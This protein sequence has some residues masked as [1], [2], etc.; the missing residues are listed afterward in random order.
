MTVFRLAR[1]SGDLVMLPRRENHGRSR[2]AGVD[3]NRTF[4]N[5]TSMAPTDNTDDDRLALFSLALPVSATPSAMVWSLWQRAAPSKF[6]SVDL[7][8][9]ASGS[10]RPVDQSSCPQCQP[11]GHR[12][13]EYGNVLLSFRFVSNSLYLVHVLQVNGSRRKDGALLGNDIEAV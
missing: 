1:R 5:A 13:L 3:P 2:H 7:V 9:V 8:R 11:I 4:V 10:R 6:E 12:V